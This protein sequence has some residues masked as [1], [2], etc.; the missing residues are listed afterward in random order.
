MW[1]I[2]K[3]AHGCEH[4]GLLTDSVKCICCFFLSPPNFFFLFLH[5]LICLQA[6]APRARR[7]RAPTRGCACSSGRASPA[8]VA[9]RHTQGRCV[10][11][12]SWSIVSSRFKYNLVTANAEVLSRLIPVLFQYRKSTF[13]WRLALIPTFDKETVLQCTC[14]TMWWRCLHHIPAPSAVWCV[15]SRSV[16]LNTTVIYIF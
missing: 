13:D 5:F 2:N 8:T 3:L 4:A 15:S 6:L 14:I 7:T 1:S 11:M 16:R 12:V 10:T 9:W